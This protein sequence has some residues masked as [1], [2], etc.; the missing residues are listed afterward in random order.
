MRR[1]LEGVRALG[2][3]ALYSALLSGYA[4]VG[5]D[6]GKEQ[7]RLLA[8]ALTAMFVRYNVIAGR[9][10]TVMGVDGVRSRR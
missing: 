9:E 5:E 3:K 10:T 4:V 2:A 7:L 8:G 6:D 1:L